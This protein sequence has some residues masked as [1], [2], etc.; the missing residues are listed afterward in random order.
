MY[1]RRKEDI[2]K[3]A[4]KKQG[5]LQS[6]YSEPEVV[7]KDGE[8]EVKNKISLKKILSSSVFGFVILWA[9]WCTSTLYGYGSRIDVVDSR[10]D[11]ILTSLSD[12]IEERKNDKSV[13]H[14]RIT[15]ND[16]NNREQRRLIQNAIQEYRMATFD[17]IDKSEERL[18]NMM[19]KILE[20]QE[21][22]KKKIPE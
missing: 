5:N 21:D 8:Y 3:D 15:K 12:E 20:I 13:L 4:K 6:L 18:I 10:L 11:S 7:E 14:M 17:R 2:I 19:V 1:K 9:V 16:D 22:I